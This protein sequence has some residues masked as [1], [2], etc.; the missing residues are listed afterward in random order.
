M[1]VVDD[2]SGVARM[3]RGADREAQPPEQEAGSTL[4]SR[5]LGSVAIVVAE[6]PTVVLGHPFY[7]DVV[8]GAD[9]VL[10]ERSILPVLLTV[11]TDRCSELTQAFLVDRKVDGAFLINCRE[12]DPLL[13]RVVES[14][15]PTVILGLPPKGM[16]VDSVDVD[17]RRAGAVAV[18][19]LIGLGRRRIATVT[20]NLLMT[21]GT[22]RLLG[23]RDA[24]AAAGIAA[25]QTMEESGDYLADRAYLATERL[26]VRHPDLDGLFVASDPMAAAALRV[27]LRAHRRVPEDVALIG[28]D[29]SP[30]SWASRPQLSTIRQPAEDMA[31]E[32]VALLLRRVEDP[33]T[34]P[35]RV[36]L[37]A[38]L[39]CRE[40]TLGPQAGAFG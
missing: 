32:A 19:H 34:P 1:R 33:T 26:L 8:A 36:I 13:G 6:L 38:E 20:G 3:P 14:G 17:N 18:G 21:S 29:D 37:P 27:L 31:R 28:F 24:L 15:L 2:E 10:A 9:A 5:T 12:G 39:I 4:M 30:I 22:E 35:E 11:G 23:Y 7:G 25:D 16:A 40:S